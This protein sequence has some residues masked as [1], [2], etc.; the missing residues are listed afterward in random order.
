MRLPTTRTFTARD[1]GPISVS[2]EATDKLITLK[3]CQE[4]VVQFYP[5]EASQL[6]EF[7]SQALA[8]VYR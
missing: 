5:D 6:M 2:V 1:R 4:T 7:L 3:V 8:E